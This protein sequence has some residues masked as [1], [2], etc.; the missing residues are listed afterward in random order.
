MDFES[1]E[2]LY[3]G[4][5]ARN[6]GIISG[7]FVVL[8]FFDA[9]FYAMLIA[10][11]TAVRGNNYLS[12]PPDYYGSFEP[13]ADHMAYRSKSNPETLY[14]WVKG[15]D[16]DM[17]AALAD[18]PLSSGFWCPGNNDYVCPTSMDAYTPPNEGCT[19]GSYGVGGCYNP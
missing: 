14:P 11:G 13:L 4:I 9:F 19:A 18:Y 10:L 7:I 6:W 3:A 12:M 16:G 5:S 8:W 1:Q 17:P 2:K 15:W